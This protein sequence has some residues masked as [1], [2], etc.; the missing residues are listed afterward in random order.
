MGYVAPEFCR[1]SRYA[2]LV[3]DV[4]KNIRILGVLAGADMPIPQ[5]MQWVDSATVVLAADGGANR[6]HEW[7]VAPNTTIG[8]LDSITES[9]T[10]IQMRLIHDEDQDSTDCDKLLAF[11]YA[12][13]YTS[14]TLAGVEGDLLDHVIGTIQ[15]A[16]RSRI[17]VRLALR[18]G[19]G[20][21]LKAPVRRSFQTTPGS[22]FSVIPLE[23]C[24]GVTLIGTKW[25]L[26]NATLEPLGL[27]S[28]SNLSQ[29]ST[30]NVSIDA[31]L[32]FVFM[33]TDGSPRW[34]D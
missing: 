9:T 1:E 6:L 23:R 17:E 29:E 27:T 25:L 15:S 4:P 34:E 31:G 7:E 20:L 5:L 12:E 2:R 26:E 19:V 30:V 22:R 3:V 18:R 13:G 8:D 14:I 28:L 24:E 33:E 32:A 10:R 21:I 16:G 11:A